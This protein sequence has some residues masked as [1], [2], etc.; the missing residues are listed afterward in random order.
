MLKPAPPPE[1]PSIGD[2][3]ARLFDEAK[4]YVEAEAHLLQVKAKAQVAKYSRAAQLG[5]AAAVC[6]LAALVALAVTLVIGLATW[7]GPFGGGLVA[8]ALFAMPAAALAYAAKRSVD[9]AD[10]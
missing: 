10:D 3:V 6:A 8:V 7:L 9:H 5:G 1:A 2:L 4:A